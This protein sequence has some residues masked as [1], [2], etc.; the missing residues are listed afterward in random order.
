VS[1]SGE[2]GADANRPDSRIATASFQGGDGTT[3]AFDLRLVDEGAVA[4]AWP[5]VPAPA[6]M[7]WSGFNIDLDAT[8]WRVEERLER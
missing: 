5:T 2:L 3:C 1:A 4:V 8:Y 6:C 7:R